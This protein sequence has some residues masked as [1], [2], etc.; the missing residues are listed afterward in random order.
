MP[1]AHIVIQGRLSSSRLPGKALLPIGGLPSLVLCARRAANRGGKVL[2]ATST[3]SSDDALTQ[4]LQQHHIPF[5]CGPLD[6]VLGR[7]EL[8]TRGL[9]D[10]DA[11]VRLTG[12]NLLPDGDFVQQLTKAFFME[13]APHLGTSS[14]IDRLPYGLSAEIFR[15]R[16]LREAHVFATAAADREHVTTWIRRQYGTRIFTPTGLPKDFGHLRCTLDDFDDY[17]RLLKLFEAVADPVY[18]PWVDLVG[19]LSELPDEPRSRVPFRVKQGGIHSEL[20]I[21]SAQ[22]GMRYGAANT[23]GMPSP[24]EVQSIVRTAVAYGVTAI[25]TA[26]VYGEAEMRLGEALFGSWG[27]RVSVITKLDTMMDLCDETSPAA[28]RNAV[29]A[30]V[31]RS[32]RELRTQRL[33]TVLLH[34]WRHRHACGGTIWS[35]LLELREQGVIQNL[36]TSVSVPSEALEALFDED[37]KHIQ[38]PFNVLDWRWKAAGFDRA[39]RNRDDVVVHGR[40]AFLQGLLVNGPAIWPHLRHGSASDWVNKLNCLV[41]EL[42]RESTQDLCLAYVRAQTWMTS[43]VVGCETLAQLQQNI[44]LFQVPKLSEGECARVEDVLAG[45]GEELL[46][47]SQWSRSS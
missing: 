6:D 4:T 2:I 38:V 20:A 45:A 25:D 33:H 17:L 31:F 13:D 11:V 44:R 19:K 37:V 27:E 23:L 9:P 42:G 26:R 10:D 41:A 15:V 32:C 5:V 1:E 21:G 7:F 3:H 46:D 29:D 24:M 16:T 43:I 36:G 34:R 18:T 12:D 35:R 22:L 39:C 8:A 47:P 14:P 30:S 40:S 28:F